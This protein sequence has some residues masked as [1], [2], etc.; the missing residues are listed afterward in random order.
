MAVTNSK[1]NEVFNSQKEDSF[2]YVASQY[3]DKQRVYNF[4]KSRF[5]HDALN[6]MRYR[7]IYVLIQTELWYPIPFQALEAS[8]AIELS[9]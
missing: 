8:E 1:Y 2:D 7:D 3:P 9:Y 6:V 4:L 5:G